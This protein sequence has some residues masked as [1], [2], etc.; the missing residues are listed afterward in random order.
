MSSIVELGAGH[1]EVTKYILAEKWKDSKFIT[2][3]NDLD[4]YEAVKIEY[5][6]SCEVSNL[7]ADKIS[8]IIP[9]NS[10][11]VVFS[12]LPLWSIDEKKVDTI[13]ASI[14]SILKPGGYYIQ[15]QYW[16][17]NRSQIKKYFHIEKTLW[18]PRNIW[19]AFIYVARKEK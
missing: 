17:W 16:M 18:E 11:D 14:E 3:E 4:R 6:Q 5:G 15:Y 7:D 13:L 1:G 8:E 2:L 10:V 19:P 9:S 12:T